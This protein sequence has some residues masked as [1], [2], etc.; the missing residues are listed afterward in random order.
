MSGL[1]SGLAA[2]LSLVVAALLWMRTAAADWAMNLPTPVSPLGVKILNLHNLILIICVIIFVLVFGVMFYSIFAHRRSRGVEASKFSHHT[3]LEVVWTAIPAVIL[4]AM[5]VPSTATLIDME[6]T[7]KADMSVKVTG[8][9]WLWQ[10]E[11]MDD[12]VSFYSRLATP[13]AQIDNL[14]PKDEHYLLEVDK[15]LVLPVDTRI[16][17]LIT[18]AD[19]VH[20]WWVPELGVKKDAIPGYINEVW[21]RITKEGIYRGQCAELCGKDHGFMP[22]VVKAVSKEKFREWVAARQDNADAGD[23]EQARAGAAS[24][25]GAQPPMTLAQ[26]ASAAQ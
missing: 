15:P 20:A 3:G 23:G 2:S 22:I 14:A 26:G 25:A 9:Q 11:Y 10:Y 17:I 18:A 5:A 1:K 8:Y 16:R 7:S 4:V 12:D 21:T 19:V 13:S 6:D 24:P